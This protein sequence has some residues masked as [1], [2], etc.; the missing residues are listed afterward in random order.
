MKS[1]GFYMLSIC[2]Y[3]CIDFL[4]FPT[5]MPF[6]SFPYL[7]A[8]ARISITINMFNNRGKKICSC[9]F[10]IL[11]ETFSAV[12]LKY[13]VSN[14]FVIYTSLYVEVC[15]PYPLCW[16]FLS[17]MDVE[18]YQVIFLH[19][20]GIYQLIFILHFCQCDIKLNGLQRLNRL[21]SPE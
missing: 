17:Q 3:T 6:I 2:F 7:I 20:L 13:D 1:L 16:E 9:S 21:A 19:L 8:M 15:S 4:H 5:W 18:F 11:E 12:H 10:Q 14:G